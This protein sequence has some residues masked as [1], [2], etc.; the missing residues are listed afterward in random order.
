M[1]RGRNAIAVALRTPTAA[2]S[3]RPSRST[4]R[5]RATHWAKLPV[6]PRA[7]RPVRDARAG[8]RWLI[9]S[10]N[11]SASEEGVELGTGGVAIMLTITLALGIGIF[12]FLPAAHHAGGRC[13]SE[14]GILFHA[15]EGVVQVAIFLG[16][17]LLIGRSGE[18]K[19]TF[20]YHGAEHMSI[21]AL[22]NGDPLTTERVRLLP[23][24]PPALRHRVPRRRHHHLDH[25]LLDSSGGSRS[26]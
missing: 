3:A 8:T 1:M 5:F 19:R 13:P 20:Q 24:R 25:R 14:Q 4:G 9:R 23:H 12:F 21:H 15:A 22:E 26:S 11:L 17:L 16:Y 6:R 18:V 2:S 10:A 7:R